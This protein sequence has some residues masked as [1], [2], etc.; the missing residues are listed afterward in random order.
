[1][2][3][4]YSQKAVKQ[5]KKIRLGDKKSAKMILETIEA[6]AI[7]PAGHFNI[8]HLKGDMGD[9]KRLRAGRYR[10]IFDDENRVM[11]VYEVKHRQGAYND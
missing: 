6:Y 1:M 3:I 5:L 9:F 7:N 11:F 10:I 8:K 2:K 4:K